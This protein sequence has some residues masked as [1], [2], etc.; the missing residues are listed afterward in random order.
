V[1]HNILA[2]RAI[3][4]AMTGKKV[5]LVYNSYKDK[6]YSEILHVLKPLIR[7]VEI[8]DVEDERVEAPELLEAALREHALSFGQFTGIKKDKDYLVFGSFSVVEQ[9]L[10]EYYAQ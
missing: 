7:H 5:I 2:A 10:K 4:K 1:G 9:F 8:I 6:A 3:V